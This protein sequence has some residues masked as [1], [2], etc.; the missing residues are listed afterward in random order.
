MSP[1]VLDEDAEK[2]Q[3]EGRVVVEEKMQDGEQDRPKRKFDGARRG[4]VSY[5]GLNENKENEGS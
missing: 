2:E 5:G 4:T 1:Y 3:S